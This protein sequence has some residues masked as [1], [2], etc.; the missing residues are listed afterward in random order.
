MGRSATQGRPAA[1][2]VAGRFE[3]LARWPI[4]ALCLLSFV[5]SL[6][7]FAPW[8]WWPLGYVVLVPWLVAVGAAKSKRWIFLGS[9]LLGAVFFLFHL[10]WLYDTTPEGYVGAAFYL[11]IYFLLATAVLRHAIRHRRVPM[12]VAFPVIWVATEIMRAY[13]PLLGFPWFFLGHSQIRLL[14]MVQVADLAGVYGVTFVVAMVNGLLAELLLA[15]AA[16]RWGGGSGEEDKAGDGQ[17]ESKLPNKWRL[18]ASIMSIVSAR[19][20]A[21]L[22]T[23]IVVAATF[24]YG[25]FRLHQSPFTDGPLVAVLQGDY[26]LKADPNDPGTSDEDKEAVY[27]G[28]AAQAMAEHPDLDLIALPESPWYMYLNTEMRSSSLPLPADVSPDRWRRYVAEQLAQHER[29]LR[30][31][32]DH[33][34]SV[35]VGAMSFV[36]HGKHAEPAEERF[37]SAFLYT[38]GDP[39][40]QRYDKIHLVPFGEY[41]PFRYTKLHWLY[42]F[43]NDGPWNP[44]G[45][46]LRPGGKP[47]DYSLTA[48]NDFTV[49]KLPK[50]AEGHNGRFGVTIC[51]EDVIPQIFRRFAGGADG[52]KRVDFMLNISNDGWFGHGTQQPQHLVNCAF[53]AIENRVG[54]ARAVNTGVS[55][56]I[57]PDGRWRNLMTDPPQAGGSGY[58]VARIKLD[59]RVTFYSLHGD[60]LGFVCVILLLAA[61]GDGAVGWWLRRPRRQQRMNSR[62]KILDEKHANWPT[63]KM[64]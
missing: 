47:R 15:W 22:I 10:R 51:Y 31:A 39:E 30:L 59:P 21:V 20:P 38:P 1:Q 26:L 24:G 63:K 17:A 35:V 56:F 36:V 9:Y 8:S 43:L 55:G 57:D 58:R 27:R 7:L 48:G 11:A 25:L 49:M 32:A 33:K 41:V 16:M 54:V 45:R 64:E 13:A 4:F 46:P 6:P 61:V 42:R 23:L 34:V 40:P 18:V 29:W 62:P 50:T 14:P 28:M 2:V 60:V 52:T 19:L 12:F 53:R 44:W 37:N 5:L 3:L